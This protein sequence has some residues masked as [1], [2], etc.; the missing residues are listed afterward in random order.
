M[1]AQGPGVQ[2]KVTWKIIDRGKAF[3]PRTGASFQTNQE[4]VPRELKESVDYVFCLTV[5][6][7]YFLA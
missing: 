4:E 1:G 3:S 2:P 6:S 7:F 5:V